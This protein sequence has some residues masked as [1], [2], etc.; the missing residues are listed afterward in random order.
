MHLQ[1][2]PEMQSPGDGKS[3]GEEDGRSLVRGV[4]VETPGN[5]AGSQYNA[6]R[7]RL[8]ENEIYLVSRQT[9]STMRYT[10]KPK[11]M[12]EEIILRRKEIPDGSLLQ[13]S[14]PQVI[15]SKHDPRFN[16]NP[17]CRALPNQLDT[18]QNESARGSAGAS[19]ERAATVAT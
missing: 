2:L 3:N 14:S 19:H 10:E 13:L 17:K 6:Q 12:A 5:C 15:T 18:H 7:V 8:R 1:A 16:K 4:E 9:Y 11:S